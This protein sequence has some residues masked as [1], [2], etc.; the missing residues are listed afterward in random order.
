[1]L[2]TQKQKHCALCTAGLL[3]LVINFKRFLRIS[4][5]TIRGKLNFTYGT[6]ITGLVAGKEIT[7]NGANTLCL[8]MHDGNDKQRLKDI[9]WEKSV[10]DT[11]L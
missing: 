5:R 2:P 6:Y 3:H 8:Q 9:L 7:V 1:M 11:M 4:I 10:C